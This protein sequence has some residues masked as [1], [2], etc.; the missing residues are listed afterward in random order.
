MTST[1]NSHGRRWMGVVAA[2]ALVWSLAT[3]LPAHPA[4]SSYRSFAIP[5]GSDARSI[6]QGPDGNLWFTLP[7]VNKIG[8]ITPAGAVTEF[9]LPVAGSQPCGIA[10]GS[11]GNLWFTQT[12]REGVIARITPAGIITE[13]S[14]PNSYQSVQSGSCDLVTGPDG[15][16]W[17]GEAGRGGLGTLQRTDLSGMVEMIPRTSP[18]LGFGP[19][20]IA[21]GGDGAVWA[22]AHREPQLARATTDGATSKVTL[23]RGWYDD[24]AG[25]PDGNVW[26]VGT[27]MDTGAAVL[28]VTPG[29]HITEFTVPGGRCS[30]C[31]SRPVAITNGPQG[32]LWYLDEQ[33]DQVGSVTTNGAFVAYD[34]PEKGLRLFD[35]TAGAD[36][37]LWFIENGPHRIGRLSPSSV[38][39]TTST[40]S[41]TLPT[42]VPNA[43]SIVG[44]SVP[45]TTRPVGQS[46]ATTQTRAQP[47]VTEGKGRGAPAGKEPVPA[48]D[49]SIAQLSRPAGVALPAAPP[50]GR[51]GLPGML[52]ATAAAAL[53]GASLALL[54]LRRRAAD[55]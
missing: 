55:A 5:S 33:R 21:V 12:A 20:R 44:G 18:T 39:P 45:V 52:V 16:L 4:P 26:T 32:K 2:L 6:V 1:G 42:I 9:T 49:A 41:Q 14:G 17:I 28:R 40:T 31:D 24:I 34:L 38:V 29:G 46:T 48:R 3:M 10:P 25:G 15:M 50:H 54:W 27:R 23:P 19:N 35:I 11:D 53:A 37:N 13:F 36:G 43:G 30:G 51:A 22:T 7:Y 47:P 8:R